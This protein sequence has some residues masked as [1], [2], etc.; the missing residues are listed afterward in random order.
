METTRDILYNALHFPAY[1][2]TD[3]VKSYLF[4]DFDIVFMDKEFW[5][6]M[7]G[8]LE[9]NNISKIV[10]E[11]LEPNYPFIADVD[12]ADLPNGFLETVQTVNLEGYFPDAANLHMITIRTLIYPAGSREFF[13]LLLDRDYSIG[14]IGFTMPHKPEVFREYEIKNLFEGLKVNFAGNDLPGSLKDKLYKNWGR[15]LS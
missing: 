14:I 9:K 15:A 7:K 6:I 12:V 10:V 4:V 5:Q 1:I 8:F 3:A 2:F 13:C 11:N